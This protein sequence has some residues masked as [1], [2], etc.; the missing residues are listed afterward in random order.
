[1]ENYNNHWAPESIWIDTTKTRFATRN[2]LEDFPLG[3]AINDLREQYPDFVPI[4]RVQNY[5]LE[6]KHNR[7]SKSQFTSQ[8]WQDKEVLLLILCVR[9]QANIH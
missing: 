2:S 9:G 4:L 6:G 1:M 3:L 8:S 7:L 5:P